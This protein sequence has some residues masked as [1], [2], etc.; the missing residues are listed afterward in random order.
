MIRVARNSAALLV[1]LAAMTSACSFSFSVG[2]LDY[3][4]LSEGIAEELNTTYEQFGV[5]VGDVNCPEL[6]ETPSPGDTLVCTAPVAD[7]SVRVEVTVEDEDFNVTFETLDLVYDR[8]QTADLLAGDISET[9]GLPVNLNCGTGLVA[10]APGE[11]FEC[12]ATDANGTTGTIVVT[13]E[14][15]GG[16]SWV[17]E[18]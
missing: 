9:V 10:L 14:R 7:Q 17:I 1:A 3:D 18:E 13:A 2:G 11:T 6:A 16:A 4:K 5:T 12:G 8:E 15:D